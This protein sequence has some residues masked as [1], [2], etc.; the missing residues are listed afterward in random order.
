MFDSW[1]AATQLYLEF[2]NNRFLRP[3]KNII[4]A[5]GQ[6][7]GLS[8]KDS[9]KKKKRRGENG[10]SISLSWLSLWSFI[11]ALSHVKVLPMPN[12]QL[13]IRVLLFLGHKATGKGT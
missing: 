11:L 5:F 3:K 7:T 4:R 9:K 10:L 2:S 8:S 1:S 12:F 6:K 13:K